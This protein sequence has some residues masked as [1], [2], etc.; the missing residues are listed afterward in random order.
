MKDCNFEQ[1]KAYIASC[2]KALVAF[3]GGVDSS[4]LLKLCVMV[5]GANNVVAATGI[6]SAR[7]KNDLEF[8][9]SFARSLG[10][11]HV[12]FEIDEFSIPEFINNTQSRCYYCKKNFYLKLLKFASLNGINHIFDGSN[13]DDINDFRP[14]RKAA[15]ELGIESPFE[16]FG[17]S[18][19][20]IRDF[21]RELDIEF[22]DKPSSPCL[23]SR[24]PYG[25]EITKE[26]L[27]M[28]AKAE[29]ILHSLGFFCARVR[30]HGKLAKI[31]VPKDQISLLFSDNVS[32]LIL[33]G[34]KSA[35][36]LWVA[37]DMEGFRSG[38]LNEGLQKTL[39]SITLQNL[40]EKYEKNKDLS[41]DY[42]I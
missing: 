5:F 22:W 23:A 25:E 40:V 42:A 38:S 24:V 20:M 39:S 6:F 41:L 12:Y 31:E 32:S 10:V 26:K 2:E 15:L 18:K 7:I 11:K 19:Q 3:S 29:E 16:K 36:F 1:I 37:I 35:G 30:C 13:A 21:A 4:L 28:I 34:F 17:L 9:D 14:G 33:A 8:C 27:E